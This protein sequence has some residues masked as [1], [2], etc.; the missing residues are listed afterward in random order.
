M[1]KRRSL[2]GLAGILL[3]VTIVFIYTGRA[4]LAQEPSGYSKG[5]RADIVTIDIMSK[6]GP[7]ERSE[8][9]FLHDLHTETLEKKKKDCTTCHLM[10][11]EDPSLPRPARLSLKFKRHKDLD[12]QE[13]MDIYHNEC[14]ACHKEMSDEG[15]KAGPIEAC[16]ECHLK[17]TNVSSSQ[18]PII[19]DKSLHFRH[20]EA[21]KDTETGEGDC[22]L[23]HHEYNKSTKKLFYAK[24][25]EGSC[26]Y[27][28][29]MVT[30]ENRI[31]VR[32]ASHQACV[33]CH[34][35]KL[36]Q[37]KGKTSGGE[38]VAGPVKCSGCHDLKNQQEI[39]R[40]KDVPRIK[41]NQPDI[42]L[43]QANGRNPDK[44]KSTLKMNPVPFD[45][46]AH[47]QYNDTCI[48][49]HHE[50][51]DS[52]TKTCHTQRGSRDGADIQLER[53]M[54]QIDAKISCMGCHETKQ[55]DK[56]CAGCHTFMA[57]NRKHIESTCLVCHMTPSGGGP[58]NGQKPEVFAGMLLQTRSVLKDTYSDEDIPEKIIIGEL[59]YQYGPVEFPHRKIVKT[60]VSNIV[61]NRLAGYFHAE[62][63][64]IC[65]AC[66]HN[67]PE[68]KKPPNCTSCHG[69]PFDEK[70]PLRPGL[71]AAYHQKCIGC[72]EEMNI[73]KPSPTGCADC[74][75]IVGLPQ[76]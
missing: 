54:H 42:V 17:E 3:T 40:V 62:K 59:M 39:E 69:R 30:E 68:T 45:H 4:H 16:G 66:H 13:V 8:V 34:R 74:H 70:N 47:E 64:T 27:C 28:H 21:N 60:L 29:K 1:K 7:L 52:C 57:K 22:A 20:S 12:K 35:K 53:A 10:E 41:R 33:D 37:N 49:C 73:E 46:R 9:M 26:R 55:Q 5:K 65:Q 67:S 44:Q 32:L 61:D 15:E 71:K 25:K 38:H 31:S 72:H 75:K 51:L 23:C 56:N 43:I 36:D 2:I 19:L 63:G 18:Q 50:S 24:G 58:E 14:M 48:E 11:K 6:F 76:L